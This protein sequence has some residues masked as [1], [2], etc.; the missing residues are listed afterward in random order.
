MAEQ[1]ASVYR[2]LAR[3]LADHGAS[4]RDLVGERL[5]LR[6]IGGDLRTVLEA[7]ARVL[8]ES[9]LDAGGPMPC[10][11][12]QP[13]LLAGAALELAA[14]ALVPRDRTLW[15][16]RD[17]KAELTCPCEGCARTGARIVSL[18][19]QVSLHSGSLYGIGAD[20]YEQTWNMFRTAEQLLHQCGMGF[21]DVVRVWIHMRDIDRDYAALNKARREFFQQQGLRLRPASTGVQG[22]Q[23]APVHDISMSF[24]AVKSPRGI[25][26]ARMSTPLL[27]EAWSYG[28]DF[29]RG[30]RVTEAN[31]VTL[32]VSGT[33]SLDETGRSIHPG[34]FA[35]QAERMV[36]NLQSLLDQ[37]GAT[38][39][40]VVSGV[41]YV[42]H[43]GDA[44]L[45]RAILD[46]RG[47]ASCACALVEAPLC[48][49]EL[50]CETEIVAWLPRADS[51]G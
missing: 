16:V 6:D 50:L 27:N 8:G 19:D 15:S 3:Q 9:G 46:R 49:P 39:G 1:L 41:A 38:I 26:I 20:A 22:G 23:A 34:D 18:G 33:A 12:E 25:E 44:S 40:D 43:P 21:G 35:A 31:K 29:S 2:A 48:R 47:F 11:V 42:K 14:Y 4:L 30:L 28:A 17:V 13:P 36:D 37:Q 51:E 32:H 5:H 10:L 45:L 7:R 24:E